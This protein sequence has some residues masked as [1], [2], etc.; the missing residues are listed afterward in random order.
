M[1]TILLIIGTCLVAI[2]TY[3]KSIPVTLNCTN[4]PV[5]SGQIEYLL[6]F[7]GKVKSK[8][9]WCSTGDGRF[10]VTT[11]YIDETFPGVSAEGE[12]QFSSC[13][14][15]GLLFVGVAVSD[16]FTGFNKTVYRADYSPQMGEEPLTLYV[17][18]GIDAANEIKLKCT[19][20]DSKNLR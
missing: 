5:A 14:K 20:T 10:T 9:I 3:A 6:K 13:R 11:R 17:G 19:T 7:E 2:S 1:K 15:A 12:M 4:A 16:K 18:N 8:E